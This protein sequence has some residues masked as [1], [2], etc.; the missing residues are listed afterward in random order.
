[1]QIEPIFGPSP[2]KVTCTGDGATRVTSGHARY[3][4]AV[5]RGNVYA[6]GQT[7]ATT[8]GAGLTATPTCTS[9]FNP[10]GSQV[11]GVIIYASVTSMITWGA[12]SQIWIA[13]NLGGTAPTGTAGLV[14]NV[15]TGAQQGGKIKP[16]TTISAGIGIP[17]NMV[18][19]LGVG[20]TGAMTL[21]PQIPP[22][23]GFFD[24]AIVVAPGNTLSFQCTTASGASAFGMWIYEEVPLTM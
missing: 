22:L 24:G 8:L 16:L 9:L 13:E 1:M 14:T 20:L 5:L 21:V 10:A 2:L 23:G 18:A 11:Y 15:L 19:S 4:D 3:M 12:A 17:T 6:A 7:A